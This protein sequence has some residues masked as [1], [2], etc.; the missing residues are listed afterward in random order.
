[1]SARCVAPTCRSYHQSW[2]HRR[3]RRDL[4]LPLVARA[5]IVRS[6]W[7]RLPGWLGH[8][9]CRGST[10]AERCQSGAGAYGRARPRSPSLRRGSAESG[11]NG[12]QGDPLGHSA[13]PVG[14][15]PELVE[16]ASP[17][18]QPVSRL[19]QRVFARRVTAGGGDRPS[20]GW[21]R[22]GFSLS[23]DSIDARGCGARG[24]WIW[25]LTSPPR[26]NR[27]PGVAGHLWEEA[28]PELAGNF[29]LMREVRVRVA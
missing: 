9:P 29:S 26:R 11:P 12:Y 27:R 17:R 23:R 3:R 4:G 1:M 10:T 28:L 19:C 22:R 16:F 8:L 21:P 14:C 20:G 18:T 6:R 7:S 13:R 2:G 15:R 24:G 25:Q 5:P